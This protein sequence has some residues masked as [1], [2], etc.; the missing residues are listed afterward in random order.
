[1]TSH[2]VGGL[3]PPPG[4]VPNF[5]DPPSKMPGNIAL[6]TALL[7]LVALAVA[8]RLYTRN[9]IMHA[10]FGIDDYFT[11][12]SFALSVTWSGVN[13]RGYTF[14]IGRHMWDVPADS[15]AQGLKYFTIASWIY[16]ILAISIRLAFL[17]L[18]LRLFSAGQ[19]TKYFIIG[20][21]VFVVLVNLAVMFAL[22]FR[23][24]PV[25]R[26]WDTR[27]PG[28]CVK[29]AIIPYISAVA[30]PICDIYVMALPI[31]VIWSLKLNLKKKIKVFAVFSVG[32]L[33]VIASLVRLGETPHLY[34]NADYTWLLSD[35][36]LWGTIECDVGIICV[37]LMLLPA[38]VEHHLP[39]TT[40]SA[41]L[42]S[43]TSVFRASSRGQSNA[44]DIDVLHLRGR[45]GY[46]KAQELDEHSFNMYHRTESPAIQV[47]ESTL[48]L[49]VN[50]K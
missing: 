10:K 8:V 44:S 1:M 21:I 16:H 26:S 25:E 49:S 43:F 32:I 6:H 9:R 19:K 42:R 14:G 48:D 18:Y 7:T 12:I 45:H 36:I 20:G 3:P 27:V 2:I 47:P 13:L 50:Y 23:C 33:A 15:V 40:R 22:I 38:F 30:S 37:C 31:P 34:S 28:S 24:N 39:K 46:E 4:V 29:A 41:W 17:T 35:M 11:L 5:S